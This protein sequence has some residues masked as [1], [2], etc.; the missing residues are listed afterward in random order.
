MG[1]DLPPSIWQYPFIRLIATGRPSVIMFFILTG[2]VNSLKPMK[3]SRAGSFDSALTGLVSSASRR[4]AQ[5]VLPATITT[6]IA[7]TLCQLGAFNL[8]R[9]LESEWFRTTTPPSSDS[10]ESALWNLYK[11]IITTW[12]TWVNEYERVQWTMAPLLR[13]S[14]LVYITM[15]ATMYAKS[16]TRMLVCVAMYIWFWLCAERKHLF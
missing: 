3:Q 11:N 5:L 15:L 2:F 1:P 9:R 4:C 7:W 16:H 6:L 13:S 10:L 14:N 12:K 8:A